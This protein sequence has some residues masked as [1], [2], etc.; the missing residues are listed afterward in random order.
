M[1]NLLTQKHS[2]VGFILIIIIVL[3]SLLIISG[4]LFGKERI[5]HSKI[6]SSSLQ[7]KNTTS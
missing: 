7:I 5:G 3:L 6:S 1:K 2:I 4:K